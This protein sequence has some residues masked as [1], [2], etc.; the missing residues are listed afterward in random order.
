MRILH[1]EASS[2]W[3]GQEIRILTESQVFIKHGHE[4]AIAADCNSEIAKRAHDYGVPIYP[5][6]LRKKRWSDLLALKSVIKNYRPDVISC[7][8]STDHWLSAISRLLI[9]FKVAI[10]RTRHISAP[11]NRNRTTKWLYNKGT[12]VLMTTG[13]SIRNHLL[14]D[15]FVRD[16]NIF[17]VPT[18]IDTERYIPGNRIQQRELLGLPKDHYIF[19]IVA[20]LRSWKGHTHL[21]QAFHLLNNPN[22]SLVIVGDGP[23]MANYQALAKENSQAKHIYFAGNQ[24]NVLPYLQAFDCFVLP[25]YANEGVPQA[26]L[27]AMAVGVPVIACPVG[28]IP[29]SLAHYPQSKLTEEKNPTALCQAMKE[30]ISSEV[31]SK[32]PRVRHTPFTLE[33][34]YE[35]ALKIYTQAILKQKKL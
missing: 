29:E 13:Q 4:V 12:D 3:G 34:L 24:P 8:S 9:N 20:T 22:T 23:Q 15:H 2:G 25:S 18:G 31:D 16:D 27:Q 11:V 26:L 32:L 28:G 21:L 30:Y 1:T 19:G 7:H 33:Y 6:Q 17:S 10:V 14:S 35:T 5:I